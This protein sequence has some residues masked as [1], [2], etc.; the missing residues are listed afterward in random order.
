[1]MKCCCYSTC[2]CIM[3]PILIYSV[4]R[5]QRPNWMPAPPNF[6]Q[7]LVKQKFDPSRNTAQE[8]CSICLIDF[9]E[10]DEIIPLPCDAKHYFHPACIEG[11]LKNNNSCPLCKKEITKEA[12]E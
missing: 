12:L 5:A 11:W 8:T 1:M 9:T 4:R 6:I 2:A 10:Q 7:N 3:A